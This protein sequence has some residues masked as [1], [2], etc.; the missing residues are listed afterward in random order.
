MKREGERNKKKE[1]KGGKR[2]KGEDDF[3]RVEGQKGKKEK[4]EGK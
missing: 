4:M 1:K 3:K 2:R